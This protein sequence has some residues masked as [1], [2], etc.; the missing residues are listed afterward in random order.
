MD[1]GIAN[2]KTKVA[3]GDSESGLIE[4]LINE[5][6]RFVVQSAAND[7]YQS[8]RFSEVEIPLADFWREV[9]DRWPPERA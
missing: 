5:N 3:G 6:G 8:P 7:R 9:A 1:W 2:S 4:F